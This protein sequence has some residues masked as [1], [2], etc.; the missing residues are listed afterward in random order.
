MLTS[1]SPKCSAAS[2]ISIVA[3]TIYELS[4][5]TMIHINTSKCVKS[6][7]KRIVIILA[8]FATRSD[9]RDQKMLFGFFR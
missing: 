7:N 1:Q 3:V 2:L 8:S 6:L 5:K 4:L 9:K